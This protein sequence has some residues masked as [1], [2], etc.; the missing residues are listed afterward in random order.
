MLSLILLCAY[1]DNLLWRLSRSR[2]GCH[3]GVNFVGALAYA[4]DIVLL[5]PIPFAVCKLLSVC[6]T[7]AMEYDIRFNANKSKLLVAS[8]RNRHRQ[9]VSQH[10]LLFTLAVMKEHVES[11]SHL[12]HVITSDLTENCGHCMM[13]TSKILTL[14]GEKL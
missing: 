8:R 2:V 3:L 14:H 11:F 9:L 12:D 10:T 7:F 6:Y 1:I 13:I 5:C 4:D